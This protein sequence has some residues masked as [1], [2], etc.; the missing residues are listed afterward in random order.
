[1]SSYQIFENMISILIYMKVGSGY[2]H[3][4]YSYERASVFRTG[5]WIHL[6]YDF[7]CY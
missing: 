3:S 4:K 5:H 7:V 2:V 1:M 6:A